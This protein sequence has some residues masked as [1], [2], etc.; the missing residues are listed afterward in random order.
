MSDDA[1]PPHVFGAGPAATD[2]SLITYP[3]ELTLKAIG[4]NAEPDGTP[5]QACVE[6]IVRPLIAPQTPSKVEAIASSG[7]K[8]VSV[9]VRFTATSRGQLEAV[10]AALH[11]EPRVLQTL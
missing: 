2:E 5:L 1:R 9:R 3:V 4:E 10:Y 8:Y 11:A 7:G 6:S